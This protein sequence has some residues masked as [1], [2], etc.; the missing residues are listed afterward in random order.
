MSKLILIK[1]SLSFQTTVKKRNLTFDWS[2]FNF[3]VIFGLEI[4]FDRATN[5]VLYRKVLPFGWIEGGWR[6]RFFTPKTRLSY[7]SYSIFLMDCKRYAVT[8]GR[9]PSVQ[10]PLDIHVDACQSRRILPVTLGYAS[11]EQ[12][13]N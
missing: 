10:R 8:K 4:Q 6:T 2:D 5:E 12:G 11:V 7:S 1:V 3:R 9:E 13:A